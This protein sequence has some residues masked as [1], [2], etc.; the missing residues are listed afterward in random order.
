M[1][2]NTG[3]EKAKPHIIVNVIE[4]ASNAVTLKNIIQKPTGNITIMAFDSGQGLKEN[5]SPFDTFAQ[6]IEGKAEIVIDK[7]S[8]LLESG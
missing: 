1:T 2:N 4:Y 6:I 7:E 5:T 3:L 8:Y